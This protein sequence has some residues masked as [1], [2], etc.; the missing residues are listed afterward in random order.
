MNI[1]A[2]QFGV[3]MEKLEKNVRSGLI[4][5]HYGTLSAQ[6]RL[7]LER[8]IK[9]TP[10]KSED[11]Q[12]GAIRHDLLKVFQ[13]RRPDLIATLLKVHGNGPYDGWVHDAKTGVHVRI[14]T[15][16]VIRSAGEMM[17][18]HQKQLTRRGRTRTVNDR[19]VVAPELFAGYLK[20]LYLAVGKAKAG[21]LPAASRLY[22][23]NLPSYMLRHAPGKGFFHDGRQDARPYIEARNVTK[24]SNRD[25]E[26]DRIVRGAIGARARDMEKY[27]EVQMRIALTKTGF[28]AA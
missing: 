16:G 28:S 11:Q 2:A 24:W 4:D 18:I 7:L 8:I 22:V 17:A 20:V 25:D 1:E 3:V 5:P 26:G 14:R 27:L 21:W 6:G 19:Y 15:S 9:F 12:R 10:A 23:A 13:L